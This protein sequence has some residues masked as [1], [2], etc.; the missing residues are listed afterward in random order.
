MLIFLFFKELI[1]FWL[2][3]LL[4]SDGQYIDITIDIWQYWYRKIWRCSINIDSHAHLL[5]L[6]N[7]FLINN[8]S[9]IYM[10]SNFHT[11]TCGQNS[12]ID[13]T[14]SSPSD[15]KKERS[16]ACETTKLWQKCEWTLHENEVFLDLLWF[17]YTNQVFIQL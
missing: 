3:Q 2:L 10:W 17:H 13:Q 11:N 6:I 15:L 8:S 5:Q 4:I 9:Q 16:L 14:P 1:F 12:S 7:W